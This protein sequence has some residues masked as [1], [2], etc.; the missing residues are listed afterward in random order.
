[1]IQ[2][3]LDSKKSDIYQT[4]R[5]LHEL[6]EPS[7]QEVKTSAY[8]QQKLAEAGYQ[9]QAFS[10]H[11]GF[12]ADL[13]GVSSE[14]IAIRADMD[15]VVQYVDGVLKANHSCGHD[16]HSTMLV[17]TALTLADL[18]IVPQK[19]IR[20]IFQPAEETGTGAVEM[21][22]DGV[23][24]GVTEL[25]GIHVR[26]EWEV[27]KKMAAPVIL[28]GSSVTLHGKIH[29]LQA[30]ASRPELGRNAIEAAAQ[31]IQ[32]LQGIRLE[33][34]RDY[35]VKMTKLHAGTDS[36]NVIPDE[37][38]FALD[39]RAATNSGMEELKKRTVHVLERVSALTETTIDWE[40]EGHTYAAVVNERVINR[41]KEAIKAV[42]G[43][44][45]LAP[46]CETK[47]AEDFHFYSAHY[48]HVAST[49][50]GLGCGLKH[51][52]HH[53]QMTFDLEAL[54]YGTHIL[55]KTALLAS[56]TDFQQ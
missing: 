29:G 33:A 14:I 45:G 31:V 24:E 37:A 55:T 10:G 56:Q 23:L 25:Y 26:P 49:M 39:L 28:H 4:Y 17:H 36:T 9:I 18:K 19:T 15:A 22:K 2:S 51:G 53:P 47:G 8:L 11:H 40:W 6:A 34:E 1:M 43:P 12:I 7:G 32:V 38:V 20:F 52:L 54:V 16:A 41:T 30:H 3:Y 48:P 50:I 21:I 46:A 42:L 27:D 35:S 5:D 13:A 44:G